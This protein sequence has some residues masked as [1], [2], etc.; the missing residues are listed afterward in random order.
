MFLGTFLGALGPSL[1]VGTTRHS[2][3]FT[4]MPSHQRKNIIRLALRRLS[5]S[6]KV[7]VGSSPYIL[8]HTVYG[9]EPRFCLHTKYPQKV[10][11]IP[12]AVILFTVW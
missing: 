2:P 7:V 1:K 5:A 3:T 11:I 8:M 10:T 4:R 12:H 9:I 6:L